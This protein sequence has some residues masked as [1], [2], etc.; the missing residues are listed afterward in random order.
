M[1]SK[2]KIAAQDDPERLHDYN[3]CSKKQKVS[4]EHEQEEEM[5]YRFV[6]YMRPK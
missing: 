3:M 6:Q 1:T 2:K 4:V 5:L